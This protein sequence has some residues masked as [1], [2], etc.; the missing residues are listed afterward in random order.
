[1]PDN[2][3]DQPR[4]MAEAILKQIMPE[5]WQLAQ[6]TNNLSTNVT[7][8]TRR[9]AEKAEGAA[10]RLAKVTD[11]VLRNSEALLVRS[12]QHIEA[13]A[14]AERAKIES[15]LADLEQKTIA[16]IETAATK[17]CYEVAGEIKGHASAHMDEY[18]QRLESRYKD[19]VDKT[20]HTTWQGLLG[21]I[22][23][24]AAV[25]ALGAA[26]AMTISPVTYNL[27]PRGRAALQDAADYQYLIGHADS[28]T[29]DRLG[30]ILNSRGK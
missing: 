13:Q 12:V 25:V 5:L 18:G 19:L 23:K 2:D 10:D 15:H 20:T 29:L 11:E 22:G 28:A 16:R 8:S 7:D 4:T 17:T 14:A 6:T 27:F 30:K 3:D 9:V 1:M 21:H 26:I 24:Y